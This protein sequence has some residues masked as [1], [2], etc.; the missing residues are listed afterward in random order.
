MIGS[1]LRLSAKAGAGAGRM[2]ESAI[3]NGALRRGARAAARGVLGPDDPPP[4]P[5]RRGDWLDY[6]GL[7]RPN[8]IKRMDYYFRLG[9]VRQ[10]RRRWALET[11]EIGLDEQGLRQHALI[12]GP[13]NSG[14]TASIVVPWIYGGLASGQRVVAVDVKGNL[15]DDV[16][17]YANHAGHLGARVIHWDYTDP[18]RSESWCWPADLGSEESIAVA[19]ETILG[20]ER[21]NDPTPFHHRRDM[22][23][24]TAIL[25]LVRALPRPTVSAML[26]VLVDQSR[27]CSFM[28]RA[29]PSPATRDLEELLPLAPDQFINAVSGVTVALRWLDTTGVRAVTERQSLRLADLDSG[30]Q[31]L[32]VVAPVTGGKTPETASSLILGQLMH[33]WLG[34]FRGGAQPTLLM[35][36]E[37][38]RIQRRVRLPELLSIGRAAGV[39]VVLAAQD[40]S[41]FDEQHRGE[42]LANC[43]T[44]VA[45]PGV[46]PTTTAWLAERLGERPATSLSVGTSRAAPWDRS[47]QSVTTHL[48]NVPVLGHREIATPPFEGRPAI[49]HSSLLGRRPV[50]VDLSRPDLA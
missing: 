48:E 19:V 33:R 18:R 38:P 15:F 32:V 16:R 27:L 30:G 6:R 26:D 20:R 42:I 23:I 1:A 8:E 7:A 5:D 37:A 10:P 36:D 29:G 39:S 35:L 21:D 31:L 45:L 17:A 25:S 9:H 34:G 46:S 4:P 11:H 41:Q 24:L 43:A 28:V 13:P 47:G 14:K 3:D 12:L 50:L 40:I 2:A 49:V 22:K 44:V